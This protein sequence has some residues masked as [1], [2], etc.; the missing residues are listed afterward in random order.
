[1]VG[2]ELGFFLYQCSV[3]SDDTSVRVADNE[4]GGAPVMPSSGDGR[5]GLEPRSH[6]WSFNRGMNLPEALEVRLGASE[7]VVE[8]RHR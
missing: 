4:C 1:V 8:K 5:L 2:L 3:S 7:Q 6:L